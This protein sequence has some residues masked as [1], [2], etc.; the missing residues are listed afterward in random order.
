V[1]IL[2]Y[3]FVP[4]IFDVNTVAPVL[5]V[6]CAAFMMLRTLQCVYIALI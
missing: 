3:R 4:E 1:R 5:H 6:L 2:N